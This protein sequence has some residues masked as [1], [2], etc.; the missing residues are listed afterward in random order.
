MKIPQTP[1]TLRTPL[2]LGSIPQP[3]RLPRGQVLACAGGCLWITS[4]ALAGLRD[5]DIVLEN[6]QSFVTPQAATYFVGAPRGSGV[7]SFV[8]SDATARN[9][10]ETTC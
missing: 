4:D 3:L 9:P 7:L 2:T 10:L 8:S 5:S 6:G 1:Q